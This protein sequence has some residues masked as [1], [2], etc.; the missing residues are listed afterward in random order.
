M[1]TTRLDVIQVP[2]FFKGRRE[3]TGQGQVALLFRAYRCFAEQFDSAAAY[4]LK[5]KENSSQASRQ[6]HQ[7]L[8]RRRHRTLPRVPEC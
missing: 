5:R 2:R 3:D 8:L 4:T 6:R 1:G 7:V